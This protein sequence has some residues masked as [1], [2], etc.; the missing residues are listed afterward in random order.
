MKARMQ[1][2]SSLSLLTYLVH[3]QKIVPLRPAQDRLHE[4]FQA[5]K[6][7]G[8]LVLKE[9]RLTLF[10]MNPP[11]LILNGPNVSS[12]LTLLYYIGVIFPQRDSKR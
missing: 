6:F 9:G 4:I 2:L 7:I 12:L 5:L 1:S 10:V 8:C 11:G 3:A